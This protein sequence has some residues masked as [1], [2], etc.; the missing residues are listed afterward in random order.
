VFFPVTGRPATAPI[1]NPG[2]ATRILWPSSRGPIKEDDI[3]KLAAT[4]VVAGTISMSP[5]H[6]CGDDG[7]QVPAQVAGFRHVCASR[8]PSAT[9][10]AK[11]GERPNI[12]TRNPMSAS[13][14]FS[15]KTSARCTSTPPVSRCGSAAIRKASVDAPLKEN[16]AAGIL[17]LSGWQPGMALVDPMCGSGTF[18]LEAV[19]VALDRAPGW[20]VIL[21][22]ELLK[23]FEAQNWSAST[24][25]RR[26][27]LQVP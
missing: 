14:S 24:A 2:I 25:G 27:A 26:G 4:P 5:H 22:F 18:L 6:A 16:L 1:W 12:E 9:A 21:P 13:M 23:S 11:I 20:I 17:K 8:T 3:Y 19:Q 10:S 7:D 15:P